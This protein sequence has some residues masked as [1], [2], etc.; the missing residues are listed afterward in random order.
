[1]QRSEAVPA[2]REKI[3]PLFAQGRI[4]P[5]VDQV[6]P[7]EKLVEAKAAMESNRHLGKIVLAGAV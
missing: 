5:L 2:F 1:V 7:F 3:L 4:I 6:F